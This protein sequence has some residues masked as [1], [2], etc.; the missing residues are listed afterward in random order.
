M[1]LTNACSWREP[2]LRSSMWKSE[3]A[4]RRRRMI[5][6]IG[7]TPFGQASTHL[8]Q[9]VHV[10]RPCGS[11]ASARQA[12]AVLGVARVADEAVGLGERGRAGELGVDLH[13]QAV[14][15]ARAALDA[16][17]RLGHV[18]HRLA[19]DDVFAL[20]HRL[21]CQQPRRD[22]LDLLPV[23]GVHV[24]DQVLDHRHVAHRLDHDHA[25]RRARRR[26][27]EVGVAG[28]AGLAVDAHSA[29]PA[30]RGAT[31]AADP[32]RAVEAPLRLE[33]ALEHRAVSLELDRVLVPVR[34]AHPTRGRS[35]AR[36]GR[37][38]GISTS[39]LRAATA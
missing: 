31:R 4:M 22:R 10:Y 14:R 1:F 29:G 34:A 30:D 6:P 36:A 18:D 37:N 7:L 13:R 3:P 15:D 8:K 16:G 25:V 28:E 20:G 2:L 35:G 12:L 26:L 38:S 21:L 39:S 33:D 17:H 9:C 11:S 24:D 32:D 5:C 27:V 19:V 23:D